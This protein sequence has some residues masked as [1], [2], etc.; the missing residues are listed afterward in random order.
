MIRHLMEI[1]ADTYSPEAVIVGDTNRWDIA[2]AGTFLPEAED[3]VLNWYI[4]RSDTVGDFRKVRY[5][6]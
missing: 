3:T 4:R 2:V 6:A 5:M 1:A